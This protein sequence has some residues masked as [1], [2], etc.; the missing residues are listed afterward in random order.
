MTGTSVRTSLLLRAFAIVVM[1]LG[2]FAVS[3]YALIVV[4]AIDRL[5][6]SQM[7][8]TAGELDSRVQRLLATVEITLNTSRRWGGQRQFATGSGGTVQRVLL[9]DDRESPGNL[10]GDLRP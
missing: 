7:T 6:Q 8:Q 2:V 9:P 10:V 4:P 5:A 3:T 1:A